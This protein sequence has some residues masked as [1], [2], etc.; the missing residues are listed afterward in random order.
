[1]LTRLVNDEPCKSMTDDCVMEVELDNFVPPLELKAASS[2]DVTLTQVRHFIQNGWPRH[3]PAG[4]KT[5]FRL[6]DELSVFDDVCVS[7]GIRDVIPTSLQQQVLHMAH[8]G[9]QGIVRTKQ[10]CRN[11]VWWPAINRHIETFLRDCEGCAVCEKSIKPTQPPLQPI[12]WPEKPW[13]HIQIDIFGEVQAAPLSQRFLVVVHDVHSKWP[14]IAA[15]STVTSSAIIQIL[16][17]LF[18]RWGIPEVLQSD[19]GSQFVPY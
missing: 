16:I 10:R 6:R 19:N 4:L 2:T 17:E 8:E 7:R 13:Q 15:T 11:T 18:S 1:M 5:Y 14:E 3:Q 9:H 12:P